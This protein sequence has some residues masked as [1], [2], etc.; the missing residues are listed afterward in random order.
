MGGN[1]LTALPGR[2]CPFAVADVC[3]TPLRGTVKVGKLRTLTTDPFR[4]GYRIVQPLI[5]PQAGTG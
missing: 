5:I 2:V 1:L 3:D 4:T